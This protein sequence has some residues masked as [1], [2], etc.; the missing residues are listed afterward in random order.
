M[1]K[2]IR[3]IVRTDHTDRNRCTGV[4]ASLRIAG[5]EGRL[6]DYQIEHSSELFEKL[7]D[8]LPCPPF[9]G[10]GWSP[11]CVC[12]FKTTP[13]AQEWI[14]VFRDM[15]AILEDADLEVATL[16]TDKPGMIVYEDEFQV[17]AKSDRY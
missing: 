10:A 7:N 11:E 15:I 3:F 6:P 9:E 1:A 5:E 16:T 13:E 17:V 14:L 4:V 8:G 12:W 2:F